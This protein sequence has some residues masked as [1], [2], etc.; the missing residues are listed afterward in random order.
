VAE[1]AEAPTRLGVHAVSHA[2]GAAYVLDDVDFS[3]TAG[4]VRGLVGSNGAGKSTLLR[5]LV[6]AQ[7]PLRGTVQIDGVDVAFG[8]PV[9]AHRAG[10]V[11]VHQD[12]QLFPDLD[13]A[14]NVYAI[15]HRLPR[16]RGAIDWAD[17]RLRTDAFLG[18]LGIRIEPTRKVGSLDIA[19]QKLVQI[20]RA[21][22]MRPRFLILDEPTASLERSASRVVL[23]LITRLSAS[24]LGVCFVS[25]RL[26]EVR[27][28]SD[29]I[30]VV[31]DGRVVAELERGADEQELIR[32]MLGDAAAAVAAPS[33]E[34]RRRATGTEPAVTLDG[35]VLRPGARPVSLHVTEGE[36]V[37]L[38]GLMG[39]GAES[40]AQ[41]LAGARPAADARIEVHGRAVQL[42]TPADALA[43]G[44]AFIP[45]DR[46]QLGIF[47][48]MGVK[49]NV[50]IS[51]LGEVSRW[52]VLRKRQLAE[53]ADS[54]VTQ[55]SIRTP[56]IATPV[57][58]LSGG[59]QQK[60]LA[61]RCLA[62][63]AR[64]L[65]LHE[66]THGVDVGAIRQIHALLEDFAESGGAVIIASGE[67]REL[68]KLCDRIAVF[69]DGELVEVLPAGCT[70]S[71]VM[72]VG[73]AG[74]GE[75]VH[76]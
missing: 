19:E 23:D 50:S 69:R 40:V 62:T 7:R 49:E 75:G 54:Y 64:V 3:L 38:T 61:A 36:I 12:I 21:V 67:V 68:L 52:G 71:D 11:A 13:V 20:A 5:I 51:S 27:A 32:H 58:V 53:R 45:E 2:Y 70:E 15:D 74:T 42:R 41:T 44:L 39:A 29:E 8:S 59:N 33:P 26:D 73:T 72:R 31:R 48:G 37:G 6:G 34:R 47:G 24:G 17:I 57:G 55:M 66:P 16:R 35:L 25:H 1:N 76:A 60:V 43:A 30:T 46:K 9:D 56:S 14:T 65:V 18:E 28:I 22:A 4:R 63:G 10:I